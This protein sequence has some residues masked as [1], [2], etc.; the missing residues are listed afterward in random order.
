MGQQQS[1]EAAVQHVP[2][3]HTTTRTW[4]TRESLHGGDSGGSAKGGEYDPSTVMHQI[5]LHEIQEVEKEMIDKKL[6]TPEALAQAK[7]LMMTRI[8][9]IIKTK[10]PTGLYVM[11]TNPPFKE[12]YE[13]IADSVNSKVN[14]VK[15]AHEK[16]VRKAI[17]PPRTS[18]ESEESEGSS[19][20]EGSSGSGETE[21]SG[22][23]NGNGET[24]ESGSDETEESLE[25]GDDESSIETSSESDNSETGGENDDSGVTGESDEDD[26]DDE[27]DDSGESDESDESPESIEGGANSE[28]NGSGSSSFYKNYLFL[29][30]ELIRLF[31]L[32]GLVTSVASGQP[33][34]LR[35][36]I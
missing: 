25:G 31:T 17:A 21:G 7:G 35:P 29:V 4:E 1:N 33:S 24:D 26:E 15:K 9:S 19:E 36:Q 18:S 12:V 23:G 11:L 22:T 2:Q 5:L 32:I 6:I 16:E 8:N 27:S 14:I 10:G 30:T 3:R 20:T 13:Q 28:E 34:R